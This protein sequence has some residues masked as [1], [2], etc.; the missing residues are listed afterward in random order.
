[1]IPC[2]FYISPVAYVAISLWSVMYQIIDFML[3]RPIEYLKTCETRLSDLS[4]VFN[5]KSEDTTEINRN[6]LDELTY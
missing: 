4:D 2:N 5:R 6:K 3:L 1:M